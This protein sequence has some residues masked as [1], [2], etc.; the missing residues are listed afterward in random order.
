MQKEKFPNDFYAK[1]GAIRY[2]LYKGKD[3][4]NEKT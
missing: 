4:N 1:K 2:K 3:I